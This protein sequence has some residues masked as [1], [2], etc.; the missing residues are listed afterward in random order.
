MEA[1]QTPS[2]LSEKPSTAAI[3]L[4]P[5]D[6]D[7]QTRFDTVTAGRTTSNTVQTFDSAGKPRDSTSDNND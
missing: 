1:L 4:S 5:Y 3:F 7:K 2:T 6:W